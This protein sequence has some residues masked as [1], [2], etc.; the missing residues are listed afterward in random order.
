M[1][2]RLSAGKTWNLTELTRFPASLLLISL[3]L[4]TDFHN[5]NVAYSP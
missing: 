2:V 4:V 3:S 1:E 5:T